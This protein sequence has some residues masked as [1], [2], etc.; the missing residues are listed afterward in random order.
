M[1]DYYISLGSNLGD[2]YQYIQNALDALAA[3]EGV[4]AV[5]CSSLL[6]T[7]PWGNENQGAFINGLCLCRAELEPLAMLELIQSIEKANGRE[8]NIHWGPRTLD[9]DIVWGEDEKGPLSYEDSRLQVPHPY[10]WDRTFVLIPLQQLY[11]DFSY[12]GQGIG[13]RISELEGLGA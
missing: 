4:R 12:Q 5:T 6:E 7:A 9:L 3:Q 2:R 11:P 13:D 8:R 1:K 10:F